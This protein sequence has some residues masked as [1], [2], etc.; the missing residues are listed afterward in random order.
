MNVISLFDWAGQW[1]AV[2]NQMGITPKR[3]FS[4]EVDTYAIKLLSDNFPDIEHIGSVEDVR[5]SLGELRWWNSSFQETKVDIDFLIM[6][7]PCT[8]LSIA[9]KRQG[10]WA[11]TLEEYF[12]LKRRYQNIKNWNPQNEKQEAT[13]F[14]INFFEKTQSHLFWEGVRILREVK[15]KVFFVENVSWMDKTWKE[16]YTRALFGIEPMY[17]D[18]RLTSAQ[19]RKRLY[20][21]GVRQPDGTYKGV[22]ITQPED[23]GILLKDIIEYI[24]FDAVD[25]KGELIW[26]PVPEKYLGIVEKKICIPEATKKGFV[27]LQ[28]WDCVDMAQPNS[29][30]RRGRMMRDK[31]NGITTSPQFM[32]IGRFQIPHGNNS[33]SLEK[34]CAINANGDYANNNKLVWEYEAQYYWRKLTVRECARAQSFP[35]WYSFDSISPS[36]AYKAIGNSWE[37]WAIKHIWKYLIPYVW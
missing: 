8:N 14:L 12:E 4:S 32:T 23:A 20:W 15:P 13:E 10:L 28:E 31:L 21:F 19:T 18:S 22:D 1:L 16:V 9:G 34:A 26:K 11:S 24:P 36:R 2:L 6:W 35:E 33:Y 7:P 27:E 37:G 30:T 29:A 3:Y 17:I 5:Y 25:K